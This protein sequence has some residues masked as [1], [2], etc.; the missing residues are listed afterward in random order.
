MAVT[1]GRK[2]DGLLLFIV[3]FF[4]LFGLKLA[5]VVDLQ[6]IVLLIVTLL[7]VRFRRL[8]F[9]PRYFV[10][11]VILYVLIIYILIVFAVADEPSYHELFRVVRAFVTAVLLYLLLSS[12]PFNY[13]RI[14]KLIVVVIS[15]HALFIV[16]EMLFPSFKSVM[17][18]LVGHDKILGDFR[19]FGLTSAYDTAGGYLII[20]MILS[21]SLYSQTINTKYIF[22]MLL[23]WVSGCATG[24]MFM[25]VGS[26]FFLFFISHYLIK[27]GLSYVK[28]ALLIM[29]SVMAY[30]FLL[31]VFPLLLDAYLFASG[32]RDEVSMM[33]EGSGYYVGTLSVLQ[34]HQIL[35]GNVMELIFGTGKSLTWSDIGYYKILY[36]LGLVGVVF[37]AL[38]FSCTYYA[39]KDRIIPFNKRMVVFPLLIVLLIYNYKMQVLLSRGYHEIYLLIL[40]S[41]SRW[42]LHDYPLRLAAKF[43]RSFSSS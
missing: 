23:F 24:R 43:N 4:Q 35:P 6:V 32:N 40:I 22:V 12:T 26:V 19:A 1:Y 33:Y 42:R 15:I 41:L 34:G 11:I 5:A 38:Y 37:Y 36:S 9:E 29:L 25:V 27:S 14:A 10:S 39:V 13:Q 2:T 7:Y 16:L 18:G 21:Y 20:G 3:I 31:Y 28:L 17:A 8:A 30:L